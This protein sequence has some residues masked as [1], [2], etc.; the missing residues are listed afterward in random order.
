MKFLT[1]IGYHESTKKASKQSP[2]AP[3]ENGPKDPVTPI[4]QDNEQD[5]GDFGGFPEDIDFRRSLGCGG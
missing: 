2:V 4:A 1:D 5:T 3:N